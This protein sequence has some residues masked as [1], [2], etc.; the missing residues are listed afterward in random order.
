MPLKGVFVGKTF[1]YSVTGKSM[2][3]DKPIA[4]QEE[5]VAKKKVARIEKQEQSLASTGLQNEFKELLDKNPEIVE[6]KRWV[7]VNK[8]VVGDI[9]Y[10]S[11]KGRQ[12]YIDT[13][14]NSLDIPEDNK[15]A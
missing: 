2:F 4:V 8:N 1:N 6:I 13:I 11:T 3:S 10:Y 9:R 5:L 12:V 15:H 14:M 7:K